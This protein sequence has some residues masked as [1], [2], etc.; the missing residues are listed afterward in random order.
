MRLHLP[1]TRP[2][3]PIP[4]HP[5]SCTP[6]PLHSKR[7]DAAITPVPSPKFIIPILGEC[8]VV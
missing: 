1:D 6:T 4:A 5:H 7:A 3:T 2:P 8:Y